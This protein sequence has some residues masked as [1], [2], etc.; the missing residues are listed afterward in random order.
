MHPFPADHPGL[1]SRSLRADHPAMTNTATSDT[2]SPKG[3]TGVIDGD[4]HE[5]IQAYIAHCGKA[6]QAP[7][8][9]SQKRSHLRRFARETRVRSLAEITLESL[10]DNLAALRRAGKS[11]R[12][13]NWRRQIV[14]GFLNWCVRTGR[15]LAH[16]AADAPKFDESDDQRRVRRALTDEECARLLA[17]AQS[18]D[19]GPFR[20]LWYRLALDVGLRRGELERLR[21]SDIDFDLRVLTLRGSKAKR[22]D[23]VPLLGESADALLAIKPRHF[24]PEARVFPSIVR[25]A[26]RRADFHAAGI[27]ETDDRGRVAD[28]HSL[29][30][31]LGTRLAKR[32][33]APQIAQRIMRHSSYA[34]TL[35]HYTDLQLDDMRRAML[36]LSP[37]DRASTVDSLLSW[38]DSCPAPLSG[39]HRRAI[40]ALLS[41]A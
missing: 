1:E 5:H 30:T 26:D 28:L 27:P 13:C 2:V 19:D 3:L 23:V 18:R 37:S 24:T 38:L 7:R 17:V 29:R 22:R 35:R 33:V 32:G 8:H 4:V 25:D 15:I 36:D 9:V 40:A 12:T 16:N 14:V 31:T 10:T 39:S 20:S 34:T 6:G 41:A 11:A 21:W